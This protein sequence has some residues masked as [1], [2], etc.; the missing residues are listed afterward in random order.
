[1]TAIQRCASISFGRAP[2]PNQEHFIVNKMEERIASLEQQLKALKERHQKAEARRKRDEAQ[3]AK[4]NEARRKVLAGTVVLEKV[5][6]GEIAEVQF[7]KWLD[8]APTETEDRALF[9]L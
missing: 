3:K 2:S 6:R 5:E 4:K 9:N 1:V 7:R 8:S